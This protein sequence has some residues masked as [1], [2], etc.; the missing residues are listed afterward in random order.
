MARAAWP[1]RPRTR[2]I[3]LSRLAASAKAPCARTTV[4]WTVLRVF[5][6]CFSLAWG[7]SSI[8]KPVRDGP[9][10]CAERGAFGALGFVILWFLPVRLLSALRPPAGGCIIRGVRL[11]KRNPRVPPQRWVAARMLHGRDD[12]GPGREVA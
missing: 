8:S 6:P 5:T 3:T 1:R 12:E 7:P 9:G 10:L 4:A 11:S 2:R